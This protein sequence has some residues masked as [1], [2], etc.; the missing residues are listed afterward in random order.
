M[1]ITRE[2]SLDAKYR[3]EHGVVFLSGIQAL[4][5]LPLDQ[6]RADRRRGLDTATLISGYRGSPLGGFDLTLERNQPLLRE[7][8]VVFISGLNEDLGATAVFGSQLANV[9]P[10]PKYD[11]VLG[12]WYGK[13]PGVDRTGDIFKHANF[14]GIGKHGGVLALGGDDP[15]SKSSTLPTHSEVAFY[16]ALFPVL[17]PGSVQ[18]ILDLG[19]LGFELSRYSGLWVGFKIVTNVADEIGTAEVAAERVQIVDPGFEFEG[20]PWRHT[21][22]PLLLPPYGLE[23]EREIHYGRLEAAKAFAAVN[24]I[25]RIAVDTSDAW[26]GLVAAGKTYYDLREALRELGLDDAALGRHGIRILKVGML[27]PMEPGI[28]RQFARGLEEILVVEEKR[29]FVEL[30]VRDALYNDAVHPRVVGKRDEQGRPLVPANGEL[31]ADRIAQLVASRLE[32]KLH[33]GSITA[34]VALLEALRERPQPITLARQPYFCSG[35]PH[36]RSTTVPDGSMAAAGI[37]CHGMA[38]SMPERRTMGITHMGGEGAQWVGMAPFSNMPHMF[39][40]LGDGTFFH[41]GSLAVRQAIAAG[42]NITYKILYNSAVA[43]TGGQDAAG[44]VPVP[45]LT[46]ML[47]AEGVRRI[48]VMTDEPAKYGRS[49]RFADGVEVWHRDRLDEAQKLLRDTP[50]VTALVYDQRC[51]AEKRRLRKRGRLPDPAMRVVIN[52]AVCEGCGDCG[53]KSNCLSVHPVETEFGRKTQIHQSSCNK[54]Y[55]CLRG[56]CPSFLTVVPLGEPKKKERAR[57]SVD[58]VLP[59]PVLKVPRDASV[60]MMGIGGTGVVTVNQVLGTAALLDGKHVRGLDQTGLSQKGGPVVSHLK[61]SEQPSEVS[62]KVAAGAADC[63]LGFDVLVATASVN[64]DH[65]GPDRTIAVVSTSQVPTGAMVTH[66][67]VLFPEGGGLRTSIDRVTRKDE[68]VYLDAL[69]LAETLFDDHMAANMLVLGAAYQAGAIPVS[70]AAIEQAIVLNGVSVGMNTQAFRAGRLLVADPAWVTTLTRHRLGAIESAS[71]LTAAARALVERVGAAGELARLLAIRVPELIDYQDERYARE[72]VDFVARV[73]A[74]E[75]AAVP[76]ETRLGEAVARYLFK[77]M[78]YK[79]EYEVARLHLKTDVT[80]A[81]AEE[82]PGGVRVQYNLHPPLLRAL[83]MTRKIKLGTWFDGAFRVL[84][85]LKRLR[86]TPLDPFGRAAVRRVERALP[87]EYRALVERA[88]GGL[89][90]ATYER[91]VT[92]ARLPDLIRGYE[93]IKLRNVERFRAE[94]ANLTGGPEMAPRPPI[95][96]AAPAQPWRP[97]T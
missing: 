55:S 78:A 76:G 52:E 71:T 2:F 25:N 32:R 31:D 17:F 26:L 82:F 16:D 6:H 70:A 67:D 92:L 96:Q 19:R 66:T 9:F 41:S 42:T 33:L 21:Q 34:R 59:E 91:A 46:R 90:P 8:N 38:L 93:D 77:L 54:D 56:D 81:L 40:N 73:R 45:E 22:N 58:R 36:N 80:R 75:Q 57:F 86:G 97:S 27:F 14:A 50:G 95:A 53:V 60:F 39:Q 13:G 72:Y 15:L 88:L 24:G 35:C 51:A 65:A 68:N 37:G 89:S 29:S 83:G 12:M 28:V 62:S 18:E 84:A 74:A 1:P 20:T 44:A 48:I 3:Q 63:Y 7:H 79:D 43:M 10:Q 87:A 23:M 5:R 85:R 47:E 69:G 49:A 64:L 61:I 11:G 94:A 4:V 30:F